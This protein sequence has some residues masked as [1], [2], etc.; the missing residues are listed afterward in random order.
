MQKNENEK[1]ESIPRLFLL[2][3]KII[4]KEDEDE[5]ADI[6]VREK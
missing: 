2:W 4:A 6:E 3:Q 5:K 1:N